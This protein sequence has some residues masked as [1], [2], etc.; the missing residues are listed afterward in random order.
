MRDAGG[1]RRQIRTGGQ[2]TAT[3]GQDGMHRCA[4]SYITPGTAG[5]TS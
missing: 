4:L 5:D 2:I 1:A 3:D